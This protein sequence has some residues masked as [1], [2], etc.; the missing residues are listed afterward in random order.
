MIWFGCRLC[1]NPIA[2]KAVYSPAVDDDGTP[3]VIVE[4]VAEGDHHCPR[5]N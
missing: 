4:F 3:C 2:V 1:G 5:L